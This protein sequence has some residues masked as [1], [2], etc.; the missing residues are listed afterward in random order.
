MCHL[1]PDILEVICFVQ[2]IMSGFSETLGLEE[3]SENITS[4]SI[5]V[6]SSYTS[7]SK[8][9]IVL[10]THLEKVACF[11]SFPFQLFLV[12]YMF[13][14]VCVPFPCSLVTSRGKE[15]KSL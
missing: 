12:A 14:F 8:A 15:I 11:P 6:Y 5:K 2:D 9:K 13:V 10:A 4:E 3:G 7:R 1:W